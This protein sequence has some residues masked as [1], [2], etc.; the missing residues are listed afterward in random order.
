MKTW[1][2]G[3]VRLGTCVLQI[4]TE[5]LKLFKNPYLPLKIR[6]APTLYVR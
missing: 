2:M 1:D 6:Y 3:Y 4:V 5:P